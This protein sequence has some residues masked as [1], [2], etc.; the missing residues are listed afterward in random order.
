MSGEHQIAKEAQV[1]KV[2]FLIQ[3]FRRLSG[4]KLRRAASG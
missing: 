3:V 1:K 4:V 2:P